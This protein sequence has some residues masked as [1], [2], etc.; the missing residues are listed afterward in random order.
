ISVLRG[1]KW[2]TRVGG[3]PGALRRGVPTR[4]SHF[5]WCSGA[6]KSA[7]PSLRLI[8]GYLSTRGERIPRTRGR[9]DRRGARRAPCAEQL[10]GRDRGGR[11]VQPALGGFEERAF[12]CR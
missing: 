9:A 2:E 3:V 1:A 12:A 5:A 4:V 6:L 10:E 8:P 7:C 11:L